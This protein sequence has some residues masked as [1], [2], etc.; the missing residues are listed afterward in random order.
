MVAV[1]LVVGVVVVA[2]EHTQSP[3]RHM[4]RAV[5]NSGLVTYL[6]IKVQI[7]SISGAYISLHTL[8]VN[9][10]RAW[11]LPRLK[12][13]GAAKF[14]LPHCPFQPFIKHSLN[15][16]LNLIL[17]DIRVTGGILLEFDRQRHAGAIP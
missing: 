10:W 1:F 7:P 15:A 11:L 2:G 3:A 12:G 5:K 9:E 16:L 4:S 14:Q 6:A 8:P 13:G 17:L